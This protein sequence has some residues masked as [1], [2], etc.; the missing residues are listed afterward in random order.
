[1][2]VGIGPNFAW[3][4]A[5]VSDNSHVVL[6]TFTTSVMASVEFGLEVNGF[7]PLTNV[8]EFRLDKE[9]L[10]ET[11]FSLSELC[12]DNGSEFWFSDA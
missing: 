6:G 11:V 4:D 12:S 8:S 3:W 2:M 9:F 10:F 1:M 5:R 7:F